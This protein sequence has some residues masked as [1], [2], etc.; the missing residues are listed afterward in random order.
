MRL[1]GRSARSHHPHYQLGL[2]AEPGEH[3]S[4]GIAR[5]ELEVELLARIREVLQGM[6]VDYHPYVQTC[7]SPLIELSILCTNG[8]PSSRP[9]LACC[10]PLSCGPLLACC[11]PLSCGPL[12]PASAATCGTP[13]GRTHSKPCSKPYNKPRL[14]RSCTHFPRPSRSSVARVGLPFASQPLWA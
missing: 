9:R 6:P 8:R 7:T 10:Q 12:L 11:Q 5:L 1:C 2:D 13:R 3:V 14:S 4:N